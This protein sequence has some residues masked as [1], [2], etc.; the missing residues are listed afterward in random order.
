MNEIDFDFL[1]YKVDIEQVL[2]PLFYFLSNK[3]DVEL[4]KTV[5]Q[6]YKGKVATEIICP[7]QKKGEFLFFRSMVR[8]DYAAMFDT[9]CKSINSP[10]VRVENYESRGGFNLS[11]QKIFTHC[12]PYY[13]S[14]KY[15]EG[16]VRKCLFIVYCFY[17]SVLEKVLKNKFEV[18]VFHADMQPVEN[19]LAQYIRHKLGIKTVTLQH[20]LYVDYGDVETVNVVNYKHQPCEYFL[21][22]GECTKAIIEKYNDSTVYVCGKPSFHNLGDSSVPKL[23]KISVIFD[24][25]IFDK[26]NTEM[27]NIVK[28]YIGKKDF[29]IC[30]RFHPSNN[31]K[32]YFSKFPF[33][34]ECY[35]L[36][37]SQVVVGHTSSLLYESIALGYNVIQYKTNVPAID[38]DSRRQFSGLYDFIDKIDDDMQLKSDQYID[39]FGE[40]SIELYKTALEKI[41]SI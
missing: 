15:G 2:Y 29:D 37:G 7:V 31:K 17:I 10:V 39:C 28:E 38:I 41:R 36:S 30:V 13:R 18:A 3:D 12:M 19:L 23:N 32:Y 5:M 14:F 34:K 6:W 4:K 24:Q 20:G 11:T 33:I 1:F 26:Q 21:A 9:V 8:D 16:D 25:K 22:W 40:K 35:D 27:L